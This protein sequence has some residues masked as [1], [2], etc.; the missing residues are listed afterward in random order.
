MLKGLAL[1]FLVL[2]G[3]ASLPKSSSQDYPLQ[4]YLEA[5]GELEE[6]LKEELRKIG[7][8]TAERAQADLILTVHLVK[9]AEKRD[10]HGKKV[11]FTV[12]YSIH[13]RAGRVHVPRRAI[14]RFASV[15]TS[16]QKA[17]HEAM[18]YI[19]RLMVAELEGKR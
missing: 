2:V 10:R 15:K 4:V 3:C 6:T 18:H 16:E 7:A 8:R 13:D 19:A 5:S 9:P 17:L 12:E 1:A 11:G 14:T